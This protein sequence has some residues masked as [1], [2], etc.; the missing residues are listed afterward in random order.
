MSER[1]PPLVE[2]MASSD[3]IRASLLI[4]STTVA[5][6]LCRTSSRTPFADVFSA[7]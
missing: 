3:A 1:M 5:A 2:A 6:C 7:R 4:T